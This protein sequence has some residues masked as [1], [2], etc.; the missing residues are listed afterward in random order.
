[1]FSSILSITITPISYANDTTIIIENNK[2][3]VIL[4]NKNYSEDKLIVKFKK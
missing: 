2:K 3:P 1:M 4:N